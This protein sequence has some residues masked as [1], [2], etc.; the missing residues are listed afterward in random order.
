MRNTIHYQMPIVQSF[1]AHEHARELAVI[2]DILDAEP[3]IMKLIHADLV[4]GG[5]DATTGRN[6]M[7]AEQV[8]R[9]LIV[10]QMNGFSYDELAF[11]LAD[12]NTYRS[13]CCIGICDIAPK[14]STLNRNIKKLAPDTLEKVNNL[15][16]ARAARDGIE[17]GRKVRIDCTVVETDIHEPKDSRL[18]WDCVRVLTRMLT[19]VREYG[20]IGQTPDHCRRAKRR[21][22][23]I[24][25]ARKP[26]ERIRLYRD[27]IHVTSLTV[28]DAQQAFVVLANSTDLF[29]K[30]YSMELQTVIELALRI[31]SQ[32]ERRVLHGE[33]VPAAEKVI[34]IFEP[35]SNI[36]VKGRRE[37]QF[38]HKVSLT[39]GVSGIVS[40][41]IV[42]EGNPADATI[43][44]QMIQHQKELYGR[45]PR[46]ASFD[47]GFASKDN[48]VNIK[49]LG[50]KDV[51][52]SKRRS[53][54]ITDMVKSTW[55]YKRLKNFRAGIEGII[56]FLKRCFGMS[57]CLWRGFQSFKAHAWASV[58]SANAL[59]MARHILR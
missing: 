2:N 38:G 55:V 5:I 28:Q 24:L 12:S 50:V 19:T 25:N 11:H 20:D 53:I 22:C 7:S 15:I 16:V 42:L 52:F 51:A 10:K 4:K 23:A 49:K 21:M 1:I 33:S 58:I 35:H 41:I 32:T 45:S 47:G 13:F 29:A 31:I 17:T 18:L 48:L 36:I 39:T 27:L 3:R 9:V 14:K 59:I 8:I 54:S 6:G 44:V 46:Q 34:S 57:R 30:A 43:A 26:E 56:S 37:T 40:D